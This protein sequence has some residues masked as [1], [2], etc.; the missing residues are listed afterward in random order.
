MLVA[1]WASLW[2]G[3]YRVG[4]VECAALSWVSMSSPSTD[5]F[6][7]ASDVQAIDRNMGQPL[8]GVLEGV[9]S[10]GWLA[11][12]EWGPSGELRTRL[13]VPEGV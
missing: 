12:L 13:T 5:I 2:A 8:R 3:R 11:P 4:T 9:A 10:A 6:L 7:S 1:T